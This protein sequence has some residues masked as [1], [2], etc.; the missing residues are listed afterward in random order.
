MKYFEYSPEAFALTEFLSAEECQALIERGE[1]LGFGVAPINTTSG[2]VVASQ[3]RNN[4]RA[5]VDDRGLADTLWSRFQ[6][7]APRN[8][9]GWTAIGLNERFRFYRYDQYQIFRWHSDG[10]FT[11]NEREESRYTLMFYLN[12]GFEGGFTD[13]RSFKVYPAQGMALCFHHPLL[14][15]GATVSSGR[16]YVLRTD[17][18]YRAEV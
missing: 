9:D 16:K 2:H 10:R 5:M 15:E 1:D 14:H 17:V 18:M 4:G 3:I 6:E 11:R 7:H 13:F 8:V 12:D